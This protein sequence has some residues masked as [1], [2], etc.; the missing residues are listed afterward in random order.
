MVGEFVKQ[1]QPWLFKPPIDLNKSY[2]PSIPL[3][4]EKGIC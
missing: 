4:Y 3:E 1:P 2:D